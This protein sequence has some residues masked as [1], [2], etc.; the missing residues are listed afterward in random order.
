MAKKLLQYQWSRP[1]L[2]PAKSKGGVMAKKLLRLNEVRV[3]L[4]LNRFSTH[5]LT[6]EEIAAVT[7][8][9]TPSKTGISKSTVRKALYG[10][11]KSDKTH[12]ST[13]YPGLIERGY[14]KSS[15]EG[16][17]I[18]LPDPQPSGS[19]ETEEDEE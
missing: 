5:P 13:G 4:A 3:L 17:R 7:V 10:V 8:Y 14:V 12:E 19:G 15:D 16:F 2:R 18:S 1:G 11:P 9:D 6:V